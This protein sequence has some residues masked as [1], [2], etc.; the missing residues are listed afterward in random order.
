MATD[1]LTDAINDL[2][3]R[4]IASL[5]DE[6]TVFS[7][8]GVWPLLAIMAETATPAVADELRA[9]LCF[10]P[11]DGMGTHQAAL[12]VLDWLQA[13]PGLDGAV[14]VWVKHALR[15]K[16]AW[17]ASMPAGAGGYL[18]GSGDQEMLDKWTAKHTHGLIPKFPTS[19]RGVDFVLAGSVVVKTQWV[20][21]FDCR[22]GSSM[23]RMTQGL[24]IVRTAEGVTAVRTAG[25]SKADDGSRADHDVYLVL[26]EEG[27]SA[28]AVLGKGL[29]LIRTPAPPLTYAAAQALKGPGITVRVEENYHK[30]DNGRPFVFVHTHGFSVRGGHDLLANPVFGLQRAAKASEN[31]PGITDDI[32]FVGSAGQAAVAHFTHTG[33]TAAAV[34]YMAGFGCARPIGGRATIIDVK[35]DR[36]FGFFSVE[37]K[38]GVVTFGGWVTQDEL[39]AHDAE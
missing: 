17:L 7:P 35:F 33:F 16:A 8:V 6:A 12:I 22:S 30:A 38:T 29:T 34:T 32:L 31:F 37:R 14:G 4:W 28:S 10:R 27:E 24:D 26:G 2:A 20:D 18:T 36:A 9:V 25:E 13:T 5:P 19:V 1:P 39:K 15:V 23:D 3:A 21:K 11:A